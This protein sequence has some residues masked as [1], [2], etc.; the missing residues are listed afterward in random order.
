R[1]NGPINLTSDDMSQI[2]Q[3]I[4]PPQGLSQLANDPEKRKEIA[5]EIRQVLA[6]GQEARAA[7]YADKPE[8]QRQ[9]ET[10]KTFV[11][12]QMYSEKQ[13]KAGISNP[14]QLV[15]NQEVDN[16][17]KEPG[18]QQ[19]FEQFLQDVQALGLLPSASGISDQQKEQ[20]EKNMWAPAQILQRKAVAA[21]VDKERLTQLM[22]KLQEAQVLAQKY[23]PTLSDKTKATDAEIDA[24]IAKH[25]ELDT[26]QTR[27]K[28]E[29][30]LKR[31]KA[32]EDFG[33]LA[34]EYSTDPGSKEKG[35]EL[36]WFKRGEMVKQFEDAAF[37]MQ[38]GQTSDV[39][40]TQFGFHIIQTEEKRTSKGEDG[41][42]EEEVRAR[43]ILI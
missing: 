1:R 31:V 5:H 18:V 21:G 28:A 42:D 35:G 9:L 22:I 39:I 41:K 37:G 38:P 12:A 13:R 40:E 30:V 27:A 3:S 36:P 23:L 34:Q 10:M 4:V 19:R 32:G 16:F 20:I 11:L 33:K 26:K 15:S 29:D 25:P 6:I 24:Y 8:M 7:G 17:I 2:V 43:H 14:D